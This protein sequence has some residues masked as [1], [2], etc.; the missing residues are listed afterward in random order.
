[1]CNGTF[2]GVGLRFEMQLIYDFG[3]SFSKWLF[4]SLKDHLMWKVDEKLLQ[5]LWYKILRKIQ[6]RVVNLYGKLYEMWEVEIGFV[7][8]SGVWLLNWVIC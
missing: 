1:M 8:S 4:T 5:F 7:V 3:N 2:S 6:D